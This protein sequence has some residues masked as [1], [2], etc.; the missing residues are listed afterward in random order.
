MKPAPPEVHG[1]SEKIR[2]CEAR[3]GG[4]R[5]RY[6]RAGSG[7]AL[8]LI[9][10]L[11]GYSFSWRFNIPE[12]SKH[13]TVYAPDLIGTGFSEHPLDADYS[14]RAS[15]ERML[16]FAD[17]LGLKSLHLLGTSHGGAV[18]THMAALAQE[19]RRPAIEKLI[20]VAAINPWSRHG[21]KRVT[22]LS[23]PLAAMAFRVSWNYTRRY[24]DFF[25]R[26]MYGNPKLVTKATLNGYAAG[27]AQK[28]TAEYGLAVVG[29][30]KSGLRELRDVYPKLGG[31]PTLIV[32]G[33]KDCAV[34][35]KSAY[36]LQ[37]ALPGSQL[38][39]LPHIGHLPY[40]ECP[41]EFNRVL[42]EFLSGTFR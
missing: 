34:A 12:L 39:M 15:A 26:R 27:L 37:R 19:H 7:P 16:E 13:Y 41:D 23:N 10:G 31:I 9:H 11:M 30:W 14:L 20:L 42:V 2:E 29:E 3:V 32:W 8:M 1:T 21:T 25:V 4:Y 6:L 35:P 38:V 40:E 5:L 17:Q 22:L 24:H 36:E 18:V 28:G 33:E